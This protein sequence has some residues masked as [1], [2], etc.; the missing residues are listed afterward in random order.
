M[1]NSL[2][3]FRLKFEQR[4]QQLESILSEENKGQSL[5]NL[6]KIPLNESRP[7]NFKFIYISVNTCCKLILKIIVENFVI[8]YLLNP[9]IDLPIYSNDL[10][11]NMQTHF[12]TLD[13]SNETLVQLLYKLKSNFNLIE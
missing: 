3:S 7:F 12:E 4:K 6:K 13:V 11:N 9:R 2:K 8:D 1:N 5:S 10:L